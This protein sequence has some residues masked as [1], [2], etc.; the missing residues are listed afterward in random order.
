MTQPNEA[1]SGIALREAQQTI[2]TLRAQLASSERRCGYLE[3]EAKKAGEY[4]D[5]ADRLRPLVYLYAASLKQA[6]DERYALAV[7]VEDVRAAYMTG[8]EWADRVLAVGRVLNGSPETSLALRD[9]RMKAEALGK[10]PTGAWLT[11]DD[12]IECVGDFAAHYRRQ[13]QEVSDA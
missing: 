2:S 10:L 8:G 1:Q 3:S 13:S 4:R 9:A 7:N 12:A 5:E 11:L 6:E